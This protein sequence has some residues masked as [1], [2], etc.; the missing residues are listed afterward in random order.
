VAREAI[1]VA[2]LFL[3][4]ALSRGYRTMGV[5]RP[6]A[7]W[8]GQGYFDVSRVR[9]RSQCVAPELDAYLAG[10]QYFPTQLAVVSA[11]F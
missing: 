3:M 9:P 10:P 2:D 4:T 7:R 8:M 5:A 11:A 1:I 6:T